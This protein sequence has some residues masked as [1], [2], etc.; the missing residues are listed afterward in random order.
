MGRVARM[1]IHTYRCARTTPK[2]E[3]RRDRTPQEPVFTPAD[4]HGGALVQSGR[5][6]ALSPPEDELACLAL[7]FNLCTPPFE[8]ESSTE[9]L[10]FA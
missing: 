1:N 2:R 8:T 10:L 7:A 9:E 4:F 6:I 3:L 5:P